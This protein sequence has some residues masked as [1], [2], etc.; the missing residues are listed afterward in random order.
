MPTT[1]REEILDKQQRQVT[2]QKTGND[3]EEHT[4]A[5]RNKPMTEN[6]ASDQNSEKSKEKTQVN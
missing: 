1:N 2:N 6:K 5:D 4:N 3:A